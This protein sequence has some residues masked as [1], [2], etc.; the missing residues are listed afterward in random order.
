MTA[1]HDPRSYTVKTFLPWTDG[2]GKRWRGWKLLP[3]TI[4]FVI[5]YNIV[6]WV[7]FVPAADKRGRHYWIDDDTVG[8]LLF[9]IPNLT[10]DPRQAVLSIV[11]GPWINHDSLQLIYVTA[12]LLLFGAVFE[13]REGTIRLM[14]I[15]FSTSFVAAL[16]SGFLL[17]L[18]YPHIW[19]IRFFEI[20]W[21]RNWTGGSAG[22]FGLLGALAAR[23]RRPWMLVSLF[24]AWECFIWWV[25]L[26]NYTSVFH[27]SAMATGFA[28]TCWWLPPIRGRRK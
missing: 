12:L 8:H 13:V 17:H 7:V 10:A 28:I 2:T 24:V 5:I 9:Q 11:T 18:I 23:A 4:P 15:F 3:L 21:N 26:R 16:F 6:A 1:N 25:N 22:C 27:F 19:D 14:L 20:A